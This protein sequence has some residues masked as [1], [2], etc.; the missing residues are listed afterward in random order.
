MHELYKGYLA[1]LDWYVA[2]LPD[3]RVPDLRYAAAVVLLKH[4]HW[5]E[6]RARLAEISDSYCATKPAIGFKAYDA[7]LTTYFID[8][9]IADEEAKDCAL[10]RLLQV[11]DRLGDSPCSKAPE[12]KPFLARVQ[13]IKASVKTT[14]IKRRLDIALENEEKGTNRQLGTVSR[15]RRR[16]R[17]G[18]RDGHPGPGGGWPGHGQGGRRGSG[19]RG[20]AGGT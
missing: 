5:P 18:D 19:G 20:R 16:Y 11:V 8:Y 14:V 1:A 4:R 13:E 6:A 10:G 7:V 17:G 3:E 12:A 15:G 9:N 2:N